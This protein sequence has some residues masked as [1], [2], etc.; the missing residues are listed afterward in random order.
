MAPDART[1]HE[2]VAALARAHEWRLAERT[3]AE[4][5]AAFPNQDPSVLV[6]TSLI[7]AYGKARAVGEGAS[8]S[9][10]LRAAGT[11]GGHEACA[12]ALSRRR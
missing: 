3:F 4:M 11:P 8:P 10:L 2:V 9:M 12:N 5:R 6:Y 7:S 1:Y